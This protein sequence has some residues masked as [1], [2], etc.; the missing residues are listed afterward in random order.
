MRAVCFVEEGWG[1]ANEGGLVLNKAAMN[2]RRK[3]VNRK[4]Q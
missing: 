2:S 3:R 1:V 4:E